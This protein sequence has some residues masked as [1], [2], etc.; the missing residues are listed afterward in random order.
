MA[1]QDEQIPETVTIEQDGKPMAL[2]DHPLV[3]ESPDVGHFARKAYD[4]HAELGRRIPVTVKT[5]EDKTKW[6]QEHLPK[7]YSAGLLEGPPAKPEDYGIKR[8]EK[9]PQGLEWSDERAGKLS[10]ILHENHIPKSIVPAL[11]DLHTEALMAFQPV[12]VS[13]EEAL[14][15]LREEFKE[16]TESRMEMAKRLNAEI[17]KKPEEAVFMEETGLG[18]HPIWLS[19]LMR[20]APYAQQDSSLFTDAAKP[21]STGGKGSMTPDEVRAEVADIMGNPKNPRYDG[22]HR[23]DAAVETYINSLY[24]KAHPDAKGKEVTYG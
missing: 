4:M 24:E 3:K 14:A 6:R 1:W 22:Y 7:L 15:T 16:E 19:I 21:G 10:K 12:K 9:L 20:L 5:D 13:P 2:R 8:P 11:M 18:N 17:F 23:G